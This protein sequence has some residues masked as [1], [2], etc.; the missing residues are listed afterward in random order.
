MVHPL[1]NFKTILYISFITVLIKLFKKNRVDNPNNF[2]VKIKIKGDINELKKINKLIPQK[3]NLNNIDNIDNTDNTKNNTENN[4]ENS[5]DTN[6]D[7]ENIN[8][9]ATDKQLT[10][11]QKKELLESSLWDN[12]W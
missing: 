5:A 6:N 11:E 3:N 8:L 2:K 4:T 12:S 10:D 9:V 1:L 7:N